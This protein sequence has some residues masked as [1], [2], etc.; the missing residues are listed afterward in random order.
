MWRKGMTHINR[1]N[2]SRRENAQSVERIQ[3][4]DIQDVESY[5][6][7]LVARGVPEVPPEKRLPEDA[8]KV[9]AGLRDSF[10]RIADGPASSPSAP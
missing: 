4:A 7:S 9:L 8:K 1:H 6:A 5:V 2:E 3:E 10:K